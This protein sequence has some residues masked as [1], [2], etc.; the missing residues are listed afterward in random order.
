MR[1][2][3]L[4]PNEMLTAESQ[5]DPA[6]R[7]RHVE[8]LQLTAQVLELQLNA[9]QWREPALHRARGILIQCRREIR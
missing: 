4:R 1:V 8:R 3:D 6:S 2:V 9:P 5:N 7:W